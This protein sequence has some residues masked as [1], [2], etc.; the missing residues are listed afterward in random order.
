[1]ISVWAEGRAS[2]RCAARSR[3]TGPATAWSPW[4]RWERGSTTARTR[5]TASWWCGS[6]TEPSARRGCS[7]RSRPCRRGARAPTGVRGHGLSGVPEARRACRR[8]TARARTGAPP[9]SIAATLGRLL[10]ALHAATPESG[11][12]ST[13]DAEPVEWWT[14]PGGRTPPPR[15][16]CRP[17]TVRPWSRSWPATHPH[18]APTGFTHNDLGIEHVLVEPETG[19][20]TGVIDWSDAAF[21]DPRTTSGSSCGDLGPAALGRPTGVRA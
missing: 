8:S 12:V 15:K 21:A 19:T 10:A 16:R 6:G 14:R 9:S 11:L 13:E 4:S 2:T 20:V 1:M 7:T 3:R 5:S 18:A 17:P